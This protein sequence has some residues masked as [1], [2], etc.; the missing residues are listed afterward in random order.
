M[1][2]GEVDRK[3]LPFSLSNC[4]GDKNSCSSVDSRYE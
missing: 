4:S 2:N 3:V 1:V